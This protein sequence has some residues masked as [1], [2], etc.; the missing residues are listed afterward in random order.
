[1]IESGASFNSKK[2]KCGQ[3][4][5]KEKLNLCKIAIPKKITY[6]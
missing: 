1:M 3:M 4:V 5:I 6:E 2:Q